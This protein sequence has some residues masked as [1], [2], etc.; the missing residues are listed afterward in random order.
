MKDGGNK[1]PAGGKKDQNEG[2][3][4]ASH[5]R[6]A[7]GNDPPKFHLLPHSSPPSLPAGRRS[8]PPIDEY[9]LR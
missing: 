9:Y 1:R 4:L 2:R 6:F 8:P 7:L 5:R 3:K